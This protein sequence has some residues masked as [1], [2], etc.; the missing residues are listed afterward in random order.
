VVSIGHNPEEQLVAFART[1]FGLLAR[2]EWEAALGTIDEPNIYGTRWTRETL[3]AL[4]ENTFGPETR[5]GAEFGAPVFTDP[6]LAKGHPHPNFG[7]FDAGG[8]WLDHDVPLNGA[9]SDLTAQFEF[10][11]REDGYAAILHD[12]HVL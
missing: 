7:R 12:L 5:F 8:F 11:P 3:T 6:D 4:V 1:W 2:A 10:K 9:F